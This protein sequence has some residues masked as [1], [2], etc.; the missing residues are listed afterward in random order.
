MKRS[1][2]WVMALTLLLITGIPTAIVTI[3]LIFNYYAASPALLQR[4]GIVMTVILF[5]T[6][7][8]F[9]MAFSGYRLA[10]MCLK[11]AVGAAGVL[12]VADFFFSLLDL[13]PFGPALDFISWL[14]FC[15]LIW[16][17]L[18]RWLDI[19]ELPY[20]RPAETSYTSNLPQ[21]LPGIRWFD[22]LMI[23]CWYIF[24][25]M[26][27]MPLI[28]ASL[29]PDHRPDSFLFKFILCWSA[30]AFLASR[31]IYWKESFES[32][33]A[34]FHQH[35]SQ[36]GDEVEHYRTSTWAVPDEWAEPGE[37]IVI[38]IPTLPGKMATLV[39]IVCFVV[40]AT[41]NRGGIPV[42]LR[43]DLVIGLV[44]ALAIRVFMKSQ[45]LIDIPGKTI[46]QEFTNPFYYRNRHIELT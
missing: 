22:S 45:Y 38:G 34:Q 44:A 35:V 39:G 33:T 36:A 32:R 12:L 13:N 10:D 9:V 43:N 20:A 19:E 14:F 24:I 21:S 37:A 2:L 16:V 29:V 42:W 1:C 8:W 27:I 3:F 28:G 6:T 15:S 41:M 4:S 5:F 11:T 17:G 23:N 31:F 46:H 30:I 25:F 18:L 7:L 40:L 26:V